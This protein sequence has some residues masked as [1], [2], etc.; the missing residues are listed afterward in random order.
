MSKNANKR[1][2]RKIA[3]KAHTMTAKDLAAWYTGYTDPALQHAAQSNLA[4]G[5]QLK[6]RDKLKHNT[7]YGDGVDET[8]HRV[9]S[10][11][12][13]KGT[14]VFLNPNSAN[15]YILPGAY[16]RDMNRITRMMGENGRTQP[17]FKNTAG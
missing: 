12:A 16:S 15:S 7:R 11:H 9:V 8:G 14:G 2:R 1:N 3:A 6:K 10:G 17:A 13:D 5:K 4:T